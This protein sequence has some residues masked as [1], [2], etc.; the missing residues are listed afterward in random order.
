LQANGLLTLAQLEYMG[1]DARAAER[2]TQEAIH[3]FQLLGDDAGLG[4]ALSHGSRWAARLG[5]D[6]TAKAR[7]THALEL[8]LDAIV[9]DAEVQAKLTLERINEYANPVSALREIADR[10]RQSPSPWMLFDA[11]RLLAERLLE[12]SRLDEASAVT[13]EAATV[14][15]LI[16]RPHSDCM[17][18]CL[19]GSI[20]LA[21]HEH[22]AASLF[23]RALA[24]ARAAG[25]QRLVVHTLERRAATA[26]LER[27]FDHAIRLLREAAREGER[28]A[29]QWDPHDRLLVDS[30]HNAIH[31]AVS[32][33][34]FD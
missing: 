26:V 7:A 22:E 23:D 17:I 5:D 19:R 30:I 14:A 33:S 21:R 6:A 10:A 20:A 32:H 24:L 11:L 1:G 12:Q 28:L 4:R 34:A 8:P 13:D 9:V 27:D 31:S 18:L 16:A 2:S 15:A 29:V 25:A 3:I